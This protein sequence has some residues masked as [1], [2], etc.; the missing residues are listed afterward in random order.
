VIPATLRNSWIEPA[1]TNDPG[2]N[3][4]SQAK[5]FVERAKEIEVLLDVTRKLRSE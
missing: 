3:L 4:F 1:G 5:V 2:Y